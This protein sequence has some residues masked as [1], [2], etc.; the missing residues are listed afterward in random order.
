MI[1]Q[2]AGKHRHAVV[3]ITLVT[4]QLLMV[5]ITDHFSQPL[6]RSIT[7]QRGRPTHL[8]VAEAVA[9]DTAKVSHDQFT[10]AGQLATLLTCRIL[11]DLVDQARLGTERGNHCLEI[12]L[13][14]VTLGPSLLGVV[15]QGVK[16]GDDE[17]G[18]DDGK[19]REFE[20]VNSAQALWTRSRSEVGDEEYKEFYKSV[21]HDFEDPLSWS[22]NKVEGK[23]E[24]TSLLCL[25]K[26]APFDLYNREVPRGLKL[27]VQRVFIMDDAEQFLPLYLRFVKGVVDSNDLPLNVSRT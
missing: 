12:L 20:A 5:R 3:L 14:L 7:G 23:L 13:A 27:Y 22:H 15:E 18:E 6:G 16:H 9:V 21:S 10:A 25:P 8:L 17:E 24:Y 19:A 2:G 1:G 4:I 11:F 26:R